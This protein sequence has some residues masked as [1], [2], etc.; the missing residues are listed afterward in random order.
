[1]LDK[2]GREALGKAQAVEDVVYY[3]KAVNPRGKKI[4][5]TRTS[6][7]LL[8]AI[9]EKGKEVR[10]ALARIRDLMR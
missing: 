5:D 2:V 4:M 1:M 6:A 10:A 7:Q 8:E 9:S 3:L